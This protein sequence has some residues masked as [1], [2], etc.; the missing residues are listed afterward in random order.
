MEPNWWEILFFFFFWKYKII[1]YY[2]WASSWKYLFRMSGYNWTIQNVHYRFSNFW[3]IQ[4]SLQIVMDMGI[5]NAHGSCPLLPTSVG[6]KTNAPNT[7]V[8]RFIDKYLGTHLPTTAKI[9][10]INPLHTCKWASAL[11]FKF[12]NQQMPMLKCPMPITICKCKCK[13][14]YFGLLVLAC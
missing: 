2:L 11:C 13:F 3:N 1:T 7:C 4:Y 8:L 14:V 5:A 9:S 10:K 12:W 6:W